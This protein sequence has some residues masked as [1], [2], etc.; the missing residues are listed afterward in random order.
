MEAKHAP[1]QGGILIGVAIC[2]VGLL[3]LVENFDLLPDR[4]V[5]RHWWPLILIGIGFFILTTHRFTDSGGWL[6][7]ILGTAFFLAENQYWGIRWRNIWR[8]WPLILIWIGVQ[9]LF[10]KNSRIPLAKIEKTEMEKTGK[11]I[12]HEKCLLSGIDKRIETKD[13]QGGD[14]SAILGSVEL[15]LSRS[16]MNISNTTLHLSAVL[17]N[18]E[19]RVPRSWRIQVESH[20]VLG[21][22][23]NRTIADSGET[24]TLNV[25]ASSVLGNI[26]IFN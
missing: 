25:A 10:F 22:I 17:G 16:G 13:F 15:D 23:E 20:V 5:I 1:R 9:L 11:G 8:L 24:P 19:I 14:V 2:V 18:I 4:F 7:V 26:E 3:F 6:M 12:V 21:N